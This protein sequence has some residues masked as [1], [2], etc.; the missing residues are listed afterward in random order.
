MGTTDKSFT[1]HALGGLGE[2][3]MN[4]LAVEA[5]GR[6]LLVD[7]GAMFSSEG[8]GI[9]LVHPGFDL[10]T[11]RRD[12]I[13]GVVLTH[14]HEDH[15]A[16]IPFLLRELDIPVYGGTYSHG[17]LKEKLDEF[18]MA[19]RLVSRELAPQN[20]VD[21]GP[22]GVEAFSMPHSI[23]QNTGLVIDTPG[24][25]ILHTG[26]F[27][28][29]L[30]GPNRGDDVLTRL[31]VAADGRVDLLLADSTGSE[32][33]VIAGEEGEVATALDKLIASA[34]GRIFVAIFS[35]NVRRLQSIVDAAS[36][37][38]RK[39]A[40][41]GRSVQ[42]HSRVATNVGELNLPDE[43]MI[44]L[45]KAADIPRNRLLVVVSG[46][47]G[48]ARSALGRLSA[49]SHHML[50]ID[51]DDLV[52]LSSRFIPGNE[53]AIGRV[54]DRLHRLGARIVHRGIRSD[55]HVSGH[56]S[57]S[58]ILKAIKAVAPRCFVPV[59]GTYR[60]MVACASLAR[61][62]GV[63]TI[64]ITADGQSTRCD[65]GGL[66]IQE[67]RA[68]AR[69]IFI[70]GGSGLSENAI[71]DRRVLGAH[72]VLVVTFKLDDDGC[73]QDEIDIIARGV[74]QD[75]ALP[76]LAKQLRDKVKTLIDEMDLSEQENRERCPNIIR[77]ALRRY[78]SKLISREP[79]VLVSILPA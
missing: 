79:Y 33:E 42:T 61:E 23:V 17:L 14:A 78:T 75:E 68:P 62:V 56:G 46:T 24:G 34:S 67:S 69:R 63:K 70:D 32:E 37:Y 28:L 10:L 72:G 65:S 57:K 7:C 11:E 1:I 13:D 22:F 64:A 31:A 9:D 5:E 77:S 66:T 19:P 21:I 25:R 15:I 20:R 29:E 52:I 43:S 6:L 36:R 50:R 40:L 4:C 27:K 60:H 53:L 16:G 26:D 55:I 74:T 48:E 58:E 45:N 12:D 44:A 54:I 59:H 2:I 3:G 30:T 49:G 35:S 8:L 38:G 18:D 73:I 76:W 71:R 47:Q 39:V 51:K 41:C